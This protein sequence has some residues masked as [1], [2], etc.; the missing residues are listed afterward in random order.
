MRSIYIYKGH[1]KTY[2]QEDL[3]RIY[4]KYLVKEKKQ[5]ISSRYLGG[6]Q[7]VLRFF[8]E[9]LGI[10]SEREQHRNVSEQEINSRYKALIRYVV[11]DYYD[12]VKEYSH[13]NKPAPPK[14]IRIL[15]SKDINDNEELKE[16]EQGVLQE[17]AESGKLEYWPSETQVCI[18][19]NAS[20]KHSRQRNVIHIGID[21][22]GIDLK[23]K[24]ENSVRT[25]RAP[26]KSDD[27]E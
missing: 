3:A 6:L 16:I 12:Q 4:Q 10:V 13:D 21:Y 17:I 9:A 27:S 14:V 24:I 22:E 11:F 26:R 15:L 23:Q 7:K 25:Y 8:A 19:E 2:K 1:D 20:L 18:R 5:E